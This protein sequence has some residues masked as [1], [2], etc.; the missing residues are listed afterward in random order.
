MKRPNILLLMSDE[1]RA[2]FTGY[3]GNTVVKTPVLDKLARTGVV[4]DNAYA[5]S[6]ICVPSRQCMMAGQ[7]PKTCGCD[8]AWMDLAPNYHTFARRFGHYSYS[9]VCAGK[10]HHIG[11]DQMQ[12]WSKRLSGD[13]EVYPKYTEG[14]IS[15]E[16][17]RYSAGSLFN[18]KTNEGYVK[19]ARAEFGEFQR[20]DARATED[21]IAYTKNYF[22]G[23]NENRKPLFLKLSLLQPHYPF[24]T[25]Q[26][27]LDYYYDKVPI[28]VETPCGHPVLSMS[29]IETDVNVTEAEVR[30]ATATYYGMIETIDSYYGQLLDTL[31]DAGEDLD[32]WII[33]YLSDH[34]EMLG[35]HGIWEK[36][37]FYEGSVRVP[38]IIRWP[39]KFTGGTHVK[40]NVNL[41]DLF[42]T[43]CDLSNIPT[44]PGLDSRSLV[45][46]MNGDAS[47]WNNETVSQIKRHHRHHVM[48]KQ[49][50][51]K[52]QYYGEDIPEVLFDLEKDPKELTDFSNDPLYA[53][54]MIKF[55]QR[56]SELGYGQSADPE[57]VNAGYSSGIP[58][59]EA[60]A[61]T[62][63][64]LD[65]NP[66]RKK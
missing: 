21:A 56:L 61:G 48:I 30:K 45:P 13:I 52:Y 1:H 25:D 23:K 15:E 28:F 40:E 18:K 50:D 41:C 9:T 11:T 24:F 34:G 37:R 47:N 64:E 27:L 31:K 36:A 10:L 60:A 6:P 3:E 58:V 20:F 42:A 35:E 19:D 62:L 12:G 51:L 8:G 65:S 66:W 49:D 26:K 46:L 29:Q 38:M 5:P 32:E 7:L 14:L 63:W 53:D 17:D 2:D 16:L 59:S 44:Q 43:L 55:R 57:Y 54:A 4:F 33:I 39:K 22:A